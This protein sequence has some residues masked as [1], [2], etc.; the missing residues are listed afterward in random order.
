Q[1]VLYNLIA[2]SLKHAERS[3]PEIV[4]RCTKTVDTYQFSVSDNG[5]GISPDYH[6]KIFE[7]FRTLHSRDVREGA[8]MGLALVKKIVE[9]RGGQVWLESQLGRGATFTF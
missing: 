8:G 9:N 7:V 1:Q 5:P 2:N 4:I 6:A 3:D